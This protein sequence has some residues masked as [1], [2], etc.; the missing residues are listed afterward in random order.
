MPNKSMDVR[1]TRIEWIK[2]NLFILKRR[3]RRNKYKYRY[4]VIASQGTGIDVGEAYSVQ[5][6]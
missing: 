4:L 2:G 1:W 3:R 5:W 6:Y